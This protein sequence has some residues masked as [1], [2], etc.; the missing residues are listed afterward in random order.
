MRRLLLAAT[1]LLPAASRAQAPDFILTGGKIFTGTR[2]HPYVQALAVRGDRV[3]A[4]GS[5]ATVQKLAGP[6]TR[7]IAL[8][9]RVVV[10]GFND[11]HAHL[12]QGYPTGHFF[13]FP[14]SPLI[15]GPAPAEVLDTLA[16]L[17]RRVPPGTWLEAEVG[18]RV[19]NDPQLRRAALD[20]VAPAHPVALHTP[21]G[22]GCVYNSLAL[23]QLGISAASA[24]PLGGSYERQPGT[25]Q[26]TGLLNEYAD[27]NA[28]RN[29]QSRLPDSVWA[30]QLRQFGAEAV[31]WGITSVQDMA[32][33][34][35]PAQMLRVTRLAH[36]PLRHRLI[37]F[38]MT[39]PAGLLQREWQI[40][41]RHPAPLARVAGMKY[42]LDATPLDTN[43][44]RRRSYPGRPGWY[45][46]L[47]FPP[48]TIRHLLRQAL[49]S[50]QQLLLH[51]SGDSTAALVLG[52]MHELADDATWRRKR[53][54]FEHGDRLAP[55]L[56]PY[57]CLGHRGGR[58]PHPLPQPR[59]R[60]GPRGAGRYSGPV[61]LAAGGGHPARLR[62]RRAG[63]SGAEHPGGHHPGR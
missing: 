31:Q 24:D 8:R 33:E 16:A 37:A 13:D 38:P 36:L 42:I 35:P 60:P 18:L 46:H 5:T 22:H 19:F 58:K 2:A 50:P 26:L 12:P 39:T 63:E 59:P 61:S 14:S 3:V 51:V 53:V 10:P 23:S 29:L 7:R 17:V 34:L 21:W 15:A 56:S 41:D 57:S 52:F 20:R 40:A 9:G 47:N 62:L 6:R 48:D 11:A 54:R 25:R 44:V 32:S 45:G 30:R 28:R 1:L 43:A 55:D 27:W 49:A 4:V